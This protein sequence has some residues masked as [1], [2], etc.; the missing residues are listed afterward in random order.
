LHDPQSQSFAGDLKSELKALAENEGS[1]ISFYL[2]P[3][4]GMSRTRG[5]SDARDP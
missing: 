1:C 3:V 2:D 4:D 5:P